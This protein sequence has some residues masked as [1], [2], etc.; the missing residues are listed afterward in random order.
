[1][2]LVVQESLRGLFYA[3]YD[4]A[5]ALRAY[6]AEGLEARFASAAEA[7]PAPPSM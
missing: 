7:M 5:I 3:P 4:G 1:M 2:T 6:E